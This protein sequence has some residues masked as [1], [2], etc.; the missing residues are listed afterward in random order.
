M[1][2]QQFHTDLQ[3][4]MIRKYIREKMALETHCT[5]IHI[6][7]HPLTKKRGERQENIR[8]TCEGQNIGALYH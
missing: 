3:W 1:H 8:K 2:T 6:Y 7:Q 4:M 5:Y